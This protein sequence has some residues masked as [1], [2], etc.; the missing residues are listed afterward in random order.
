VRLSPDEKT[1]LFR[2]DATFCPHPGPRP[3]S[4]TLESLAHPGWYLRHVSDRLC[5]DAGADGAYF[6]IRPPLA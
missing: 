5:I 6:M 4:T 3:G 2:R 1:A